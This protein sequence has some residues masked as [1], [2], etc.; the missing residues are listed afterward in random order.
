[1]AGRGMDQVGRSCTSGILGRLVMGKRPAVME[2][3]PGASEQRVGRSRA[4][5]PVETGAD[6][7]TRTSW[8]CT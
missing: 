3:Y 7:D 5:D 2:E 6:T 8:L 1:M 4:S